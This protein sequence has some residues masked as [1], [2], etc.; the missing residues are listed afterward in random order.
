MNDKVMVVFYRLKDEKRI[1][2]FYTKRFAEW[3]K[4]FEFAKN[5]EVEFSPHPLGKDIDA[6]FKETGS[7]IY[8]IEDYNVIFGG[9]DC[10]QHI[11]VWLGSYE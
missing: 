7:D 10:I 8:C 1:T 11:N 2:S 4:F 9:N 6:E 3:L 5:N